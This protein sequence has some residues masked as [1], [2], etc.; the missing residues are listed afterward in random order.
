MSSN[1][2]GASFA[3]SGESSPLGKLSTEVKVRLSEETGELLKKQAQ[4]L[5]MGM[6][7]YLREVLI[8]KAHGYDYMR[9]VYQARLDQVAGTGTE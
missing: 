8:I 2:P 5:G 4:A 1:T 9:K 3:R 7:E 6:S